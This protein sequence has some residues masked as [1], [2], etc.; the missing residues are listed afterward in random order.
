M[1]KTF[2]KN[3]IIGD[4]NIDI[5]SNRH[6]QQVNLPVFMCA[7][8]TPKYLDHYLLLLDRP[9]KG[10]RSI[11]LIIFGSNCALRQPDLHFLEDHFNQV[12]MVKG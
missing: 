12:L 3:M 10:L 5:E 6:L 4:L 1:S 9:I 8:L 7:E 2:P 11:C